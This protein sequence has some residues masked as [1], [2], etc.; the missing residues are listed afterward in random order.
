M[1]KH[2]F[3]AVDG[4][5]TSTRG[6]DEAI[7]LGQLTGANL[8]L[9]HVIDELVFAT[10]FEPGATYMTDVLP[11]LRRQGQEVLD[12]ARA[13]VDAAGLPVESRLLECFA[14]CTADVLL[15][16]ASAWGADLVVLGTHGRR[17]VSR[18]M[19]GSDAEQIVRAST[20]PVLL[21]RDAESSRPAPAR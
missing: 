20:V 2:I 12:A 21:V 15:D 11:R 13:R 14:A 16:E 5:P 7:R 9:A 1:Y 10:G 6:L 4:S 3:V 17:G 18:L 8:L 19:L